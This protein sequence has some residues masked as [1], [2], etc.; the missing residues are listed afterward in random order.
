MATFLDKSSN[1]EITIDHYTYTIEYKFKFENAPYTFLKI[2]SNNNINNEKVHFVITRSFSECGMWRLCVIEDQYREDKN[3][4]RFYKGAHYT[5]STF[6]NLELQIYINEN[7]DKIQFIQYNK[8]DEEIKNKSFYFN[9]DNN[10]KKR[11]NINIDNKYDNIAFDTIKVN[12]RCE[13]LDERCVYAN[14]I[15]EYEQLEISFFSDY[16]YS[17]RIHNYHPV[18]AEKQ[19]NY[20]S[21]KPEEKKND[22]PRINENTSIMFDESINYGDTTIHVDGK[23]YTTIIKKIPKYPNPEHEDDFENER[24]LNDFNSGKHLLYYMIFSVTI[25][26]PKSLKNKETLSNAYMFED[27]ISLDNQIIPLYV[28]PYDIDREEKHPDVYSVESLG[29]YPIFSK[30]IFKDHKSKKKNIYKTMEMAKILDYITQTYKDDKTV[31]T[32]YKL[33]IDTYE[34]IPFFKELKTKTLEL[35]DSKKKS[36]KDGGKNKKTRKTI[37]KRQ[38]NNK[39]CNYKSITR[40]QLQR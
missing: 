1:F 13:N 6:I 23:I 5:M 12:S 31:S 30:F 37:S 22:W 32:Q 24:F 9:D 4:F 21:L 39:K 29:L 16:K 17:T 20:N 14:D 33:N 8:L 27:N 26:L 3:G 7:I 34:N 40:K 36:K 15:D 19:V 38:R 28:I 11:I 25:D 35:Q 2:K 18:D 10:I